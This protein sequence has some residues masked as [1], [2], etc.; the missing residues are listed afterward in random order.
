MWKGPSLFNASGTW[1]PIPGASFFSPKRDHPPGIRC[2]TSLHPA[3]TGTLRFKTGDRSA[4]F[5]FPFQNGSN[6]TGT[7]PFPGSEA[8]PRLLDSPE[9]RKPFRIIKQV[10]QLKGTPVVV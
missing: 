3:L 10:L 4:V 6:G 1:H 2:S 5:H 9:Q 7:I 8:T